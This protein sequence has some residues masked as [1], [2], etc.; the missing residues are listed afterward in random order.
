MKFALLIA[1]FAIGYGVRSLVSLWRRRRA[2]RSR[3]T[4]TSHDLP[5]ADAPQMRIV[6]RDELG[7]S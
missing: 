6:S 3:L 2:R 4:M 1:G 5:E 7:V